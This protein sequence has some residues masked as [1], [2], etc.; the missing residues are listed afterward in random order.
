MAVGQQLVLVWFGFRAL[1]LRIFFY[2]NL[3]LYIFKWL[4]LNGAISTYTLASLLPFGSQGLKHLLSSPF[5]EYRPL[6]YWV[7][8]YVHLGQGDLDL[9]SA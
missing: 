9:N 8:L 2:H 4:R 1:E 3:K 6:A 5:K 7:R